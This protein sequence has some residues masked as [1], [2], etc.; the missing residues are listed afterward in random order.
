MRKSQRGGIYPYLRLSRGQ[1]V[2]A[3]L[4]FTFKDLTVRLGGDEGVL[5]PL[6]QY[7]SPKGGVRLRYAV[8]DEGS[9][10]IDASATSGGTEFHYVTGVTAVC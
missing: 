1:Q 10:S 3:V 2:Q 5:S 7:P 8:V 4:P 9:A 6:G